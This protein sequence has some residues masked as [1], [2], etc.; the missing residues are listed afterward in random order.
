MKRAGE[1]YT[2]LDT[3]GSLPNGFVYRPNFLTEEEERE[4]LGF[5]ED[6]P[7]E[8][9]RLGEYTARRRVISFGWGYDFRRKKLIVGKP[10]P[11]FLTVCTR[12]IA[13][14]LDIPQSSIVEAL[15]T[16]YEPKAAIGWH[17]D[18]EE[19]ESIVGISLSGWCRLRLRPLET[20]TLRRTT[21]DVLSLTLEPRSAYV[22]QKESRYDFQHSIPPVETLRYSITFRTLPR[23]SYDHPPRIAPIAR[24]V[25][26]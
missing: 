12:K 14:W 13:K 26:R 10:L 23:H 3:S 20:S 6:L 8:H 7:F 4:L 25:T 24:R 17:V 5:I 9:S 1:Q 2:L 18:Q 11:P 22:M 21:K 15:I 16:E 19:F